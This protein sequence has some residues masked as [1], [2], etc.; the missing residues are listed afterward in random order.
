M[1]ISK[2][3][4]EEIRE[5]SDIVSLISEYI[6]L[7][8]KG[9]NYLGLCPFHNEKTPSF[10]V[11]AEKGFYHCF[12]CKAHGSV[13]DFIMDIEHI[14]FQNAVKK[15]GERVGVEVS[16]TANDVSTKDM[17]LITMHNVMVELYHQVLIGTTEGESALEYLL[18]RGFSIEDIK[19][20][21]LGLSPNMND[22]AVKALSEKGYSNEA[23]FQAGLLSRNEENF[24][25]FDRFRN[26]IM[27][28]IKN[29]KGNFVGFTSRSLDGST[30]KYLNTPETDL[31]QKR[32]LFYNLNDAF[33]IIREK[34]EVILMEGHMDV[35]KVKTTKIKNVIGLMGTSL[36]SEQ[37][38][39]LKRSCN[40]ITLMFDGDSAGQKATRS[41]GETL[42]KAGLNVYVIPLVEGQDP[43]ELIEAKGQEAFQKYVYENKQSFILYLA[44]ESMKEAKGNDLIYT[45]R[46]SMI[47]DLLK[48]LEDEVLES[49]TVQSVAEI[50]Q[51][52]ESVIFR[53]LPKKKK[54]QLVFY[55]EEPQKIIDISPRD[56]KE[57]MILKTFIN[58]QSYL[59]KFIA[60]YELEIF[61]S[62]LHY[63]IFNKL[64][65]Y[66][67]AEN[68]FLLS[69]FYSYLDED[70]KNTINRML[71][72]NLPIIDSFSQ[73]DDYINDL[74]GIKNSM[75]ERKRLQKEIEEAELLGDMNRQLELLQQL[76][77]L[78]K[79]H[80]L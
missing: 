18:E 78:D 8:K 54:Q 64:V 9:N 60:E 43:D 80:K 2:R 52:D 14:E 72:I 79:S 20:E 66:Y 73:F 69:H 6:D 62:M 36:S 70:Q 11:N 58:D 16:I 65:E 17:Q 57:K 48:Y 42:I 39:I 25:Y 10:N 15:L 59:E 32:R 38:E 29:H 46:L 7:E 55:Q 30:P 50:F 68:S 34:N 12:G 67:K 19:R 5:K 53:R 27:I 77:E 21:K 23:M 3:T 76:I 56:F 4:I 35:L 61:N 40:H 63:G 74:S 44:K 31:F 47:I 33:K 22:F 71:S 75:N 49:K 24:T 41:V 26:R 45:E 1:A 37:I 28:P 13:I 51:V